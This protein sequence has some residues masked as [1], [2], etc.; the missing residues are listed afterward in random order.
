LTLWRECCQVAGDVVPSCAKAVVPP[1]LPGLLSA[2]SLDS[3]VAQCRVPS[4]C[5]HRSS[6]WFIWCGLQFALSAPTTNVGV[7]L[8][9]QC[10]LIN[11]GYAI[12][13][14]STSVFV[15]RC[16]SSFNTTTDGLSIAHVAC[17][18]FFHL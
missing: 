2:P 12:I 18:N 11:F 14:Q 10:V 8:F 15:S 3:S 9:F 4:A 5:S 13:P 17:A 16:F 6:L 1:R 7:N